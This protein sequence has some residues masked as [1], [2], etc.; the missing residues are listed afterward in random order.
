MKNVLPPSVEY[1]SKDEM[2]GSFVLIVACS[3]SG[4]PLIA[5]FLKAVLHGWN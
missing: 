3:D 2:L 4:N 5:Y 1:V